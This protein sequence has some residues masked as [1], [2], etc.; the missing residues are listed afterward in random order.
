MIKHDG[1]ISD[2][3]G[4]VVIIYGHRSGWRAHIKRGNNG[5]SR[6]E[7]TSRLVMTTY[8]ICLEPSLQVGFESMICGTFPYKW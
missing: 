7:A 1:H 8:L 6:M 4:R 3:G 5:K 2:W